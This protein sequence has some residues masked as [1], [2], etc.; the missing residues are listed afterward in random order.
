MGGQSLREAEPGG[1][2]DWERRDSRGRVGPERRENQG[3]LRRRGLGG[4]N[5]GAYQEAGPGK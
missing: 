4:K 1:E 5:R 2:A 3:S